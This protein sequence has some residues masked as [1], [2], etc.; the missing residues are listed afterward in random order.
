MN[1]MKSETRNK[2]D[3]YLKKWLNHSNV[4]AVNLLDNSENVNRMAICRK[5]FVFYTKEAQFVCD[6]AFFVHYATSCK[7]ADTIPDEAIEF[8]S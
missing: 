1:R 7:V 8:F 6:F 4:L 3:K 5:S 2:S